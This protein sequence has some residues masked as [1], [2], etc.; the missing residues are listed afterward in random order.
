MQSKVSN[1]I[2]VTV[3]SSRI[4]AKRPMIKIN[5]NVH[6]LS[7]GTSMRHAGGKVVAL[8]ENTWMRAA[9]VGSLQE[10]GSRKINKM[11]N[12]ELSLDVDTDRSEFDLA[13]MNTIRTA[14]P[15][16]GTQISL[17]SFYEEL[18]KTTGENESM[19]RRGVSSSLGKIAVQDLL[20]SG[21]LSKDSPF[22][23]QT[24]VGKAIRQKGIEKY[25]F[26][27]VQ[28]ELDLIGKPVIIDYPKDS[29]PDFI[30][31]NDSHLPNNDL[32]NAL[33]P[34]ASQLPLH[35]HANNT[36]SCNIYL[37]I[38]SGI[39]LAFGAAALI[40][41]FAALNVATLGTAGGLALAVIGGIGFFGGGI[42][43]VVNH[44]KNSDDNQLAP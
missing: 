36:F 3:L 34:Y 29:D 24:T 1:K 39:S 20:L 38:L 5:G 26:I 16:F 31:L 10:D 44:C 41:A 12:I 21:A 13:V 23:T 27:E 8:F 42:G 32:S 40:I 28:E 18:M 17:N 35:M 2:G 22:F 6:Y 37:S 15:E 4:L 25:G 11:G 19:V 14:I 33:L 9:G 30:K 7:S 43:L